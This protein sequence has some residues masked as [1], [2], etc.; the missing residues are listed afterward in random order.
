MLA[1]TGGSLWDIASKAVSVMEMR[2][3]IL[4]K[5]VSVKSQQEIERHYFEQFRK[6]S[7]LVPR[8]IEAER[9]PMP[10]ASR[11]GA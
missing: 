5:S 7:G 10:R 9:A 1:A 6:A 3:M 11:S 2:T 4:L 8:Q